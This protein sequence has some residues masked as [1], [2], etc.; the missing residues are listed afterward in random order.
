MDVLLNI[1]NYILGFG[2]AVFVPLIM[3]IIGLIVKMS[4]KDAFFAALTLGIAFTGMNVLINFMTGAITPAAQGLAEATGISL[5][6]VDVGWPALSAIAWAWPLGV[7]CF[8]L[9]MVINLIM[10]L[11]K[12]TDTLNV[13]FWNCWTK[14]LT[15]VLTYYLCAAAGMPEGVAIA[16]GFV[17]ASVQIILELKISDAFQPTIERITGIPGVTVPHAMMLTAT[18]AY[19]IERLLE[20]IPAIENNNADA[21]WLRKKIGIFGENAVMGFI[22]GTAMGAIAYRDVQQALTLGVQ[23][24]TALQLFPMV[25]KL[26]MQALSPISDAVGDFMK[27]R[28]KGRELIIGL[29]WPILAGSNELWVTC[30]LLIPFELILAFVLAPVGNIVLPFAGIV[31]ICLVPGLL[32]VSNGNIIKMLIEGIIITPVYLLVSSSFA[33][34]VTQLALT[35]SPD[36]LANVGGDA[37]ISWSTLECPDFRWAIANAFSGNVA[38]MVVLVG[39]LALFVWMLRGFKKRN[40]ALKASE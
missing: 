33:P 3:L 2:A 1:V 12:L 13:D 18:V 16:M 25:S 39:W 7:L 28:F 24:A 23:A 30:I 17:A 34:W 26:F 40:E 35:Y 11:L 36:S 15:T 14:L 10:L 38:G 4:F 27:A 31:N 20:K 22:I 6:A 37:L 29:D 19:P 5:P 21:K 32:M 8:P 9:L